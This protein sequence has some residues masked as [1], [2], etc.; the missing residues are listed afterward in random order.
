MLAATLGLSKKCHTKI[1]KNSDRNKQK[2]LRK[3]SKFH[4]KMPV[5]FLTVTI[6]QHTKK[7]RKKRKGQA[8]KLEMEKAQQ[9]STTIRVQHPYAAGL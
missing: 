2:M 6:V 4:Q 7:R 5:I 9:L 3:I 1:L 8:H